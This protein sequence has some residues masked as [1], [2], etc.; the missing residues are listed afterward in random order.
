MEFINFQN[1]LKY[2]IN[3]VLLD[4]I[5]LEKIGDRIA[6]EEFE[7][8]QKNGNPCPTPTTDPLGYG[9]E[10]HQFVPSR[11]T[12]PM[13]M[14]CF[15]VMDFIGSIIVD[16]IRPSTTEYRI[17]QF[18][19][20]SQ[21]FFKSLANNE[22]LKTPTTAAKFENIFR[23]SIMHTF[24]PAPNYNVGYSVSYSKL[25]NEYA[26]FD[27]A[28]DGK[29]ILNVKF[30]VRIVKKGLDEFKTSIEKEDDF[31]EKAFNNYKYFLEKSYIDTTE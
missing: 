9:Y 19:K 23:H 22:D 31:S 18:M 2:Y 11:C 8:F 25:I 28:F 3:T 29:E 6:D 10:P 21:L 1:D 26:L 14:I 17:K 20:H 15:S 5:E 13:C 7:E 16:D 24:L 12:I 30:L 27:K 4:I